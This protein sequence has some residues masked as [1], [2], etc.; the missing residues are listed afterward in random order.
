MP[1]GPY[2]DF[3]TCVAAQKRRGKSDLSARKICGS[4]EQKTKHKHM[5]A[6]EKEFEEAQTLLE[7]VYTDDDLIVDGTV[8]MLEKV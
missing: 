8:L 6:S 7:Q 5:S 1:I 2:A 3:A 4:I